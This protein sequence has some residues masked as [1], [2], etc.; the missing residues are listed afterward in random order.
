MQGDQRADVNAENCRVCNSSK[1]AR[2]AR[3]GF[4][5]FRC[6]EC[7]TLQKQLTLQQ[8][9]DLN[10]SYDP[11][12]FLDSSSE[13]EIR[14]YLKVDNATRLLARVI[15][16]HLPEVRGPRRFLDVGCGMGGYLLAARS[17]GFEVLGFEPSASHARV[18][19]EH[20]KLDVVH[21]YFS[22][23]KVQGKF[24]LIMLSHVIEH[25][26]AP[27]EFIHQ[28]LGVLGPGGV[29]IVVTPN[30]EGLVATSTGTSW[31]MLNPVDHV[32]MISRRAY[33]HFDLAQ[34]AEVRHY[35]SEYTF[36][37]AASLLAALRGG[38]REDGTPDR[39]MSRPSTMRRQGTGAKLLRAA[40]SAASLPAHV[41]ARA[42]DRQACLNT[43]LVRKG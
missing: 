12:H 38:A 42:M 23:E 17:L 21:D 7:A 10:P 27:R 8:Y 37:Y 20:L 22:P 26:Y 4:R 32:T 14:E 1:G 39:G 33:D 19:R 36:E 28:L 30:A 41:M 16:A 29:L 24:D 13:R 31:P 11:G 35:T 9:L 40:L 5:W 25:I 18:A 34:R 2:F 6:D 43:I 15:A 3:R